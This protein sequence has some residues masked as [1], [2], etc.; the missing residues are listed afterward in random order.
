MR[1][2]WGHEYYNH[3]DGKLKL[4]GHVARMEVQRLEN[5]ILNAKAEGRWTIGRPRLRW[6]DRMHNYVKAQ[7][8]TGKT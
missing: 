2:V 1:V 3:Y 7:R 5:R 6:E 4:A 8:G